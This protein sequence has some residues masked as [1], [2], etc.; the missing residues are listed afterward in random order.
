MLRAH[1]VTRPPAHAV[2]AWGRK[3]SAIRAERQAHRLGLPLLR[4][5]DG[6]L[7]SF[8]MGG[9][10][11][12]L[13]VVE[14]SLGIYYD[15]SAP[16]DLEVM[17]ARNEDLLLEAPETDRAMGLLMSHRLSK[18]NHAP[19]SEL[20]HAGGRPQVLVVD[21]TF[22]DL[23]VGFGGASK[24]TF[25]QMLEAAVDENPGAQIIVKTHPE[26]SSG[27]KRGYLSHVRP[28]HLSHGSRLQIL[29]EA[30]NPIGLLQQVYS[31]YVVSSGMGFEALL[32][33]RPVRCFGLPWYSGWGV[34][35]DEQRCSRRLR[36]RS[37]RELFAA[38]YL[39]Y[40][41]YLNPETHE[42]G[43]IFDVIDWL[44]RQQRSA[45]VV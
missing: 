34:T 28:A 27:D 41:R 16:S 5:E 17:L 45:G 42:K 6:F 36:S 30:T 23:S 2:L 43:S 11:P 18:Y 40:S 32:C 19:F 7:R 14:D 21:Q 26:V 24:R 15:S 8:G 29:R 3:P 39:R 1:L 20:T 44:V 25:A 10:F 12:A 35:Q 22:G 4:I 31:V 37:V 9:N 33:G 38:G 13:S